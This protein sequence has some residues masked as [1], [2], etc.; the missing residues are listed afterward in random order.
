MERTIYMDDGL[1][2]F[3]KERSDQYKLYPSDK[4]WKNIHRSVQPKRRWN[5]VVLT[6]LMLTISSRLVETSDYHQFPNF[7]YLVNLPS[8]V[9]ASQPS[10]ERVFAE[11]ATV[12]PGLPVSYSFTKHEP[13]PLSVEVKNIPISDTRKILDIQ[14]DMKEEILLPEETAIAANETNLP[15]IRELGLIVRNV[16]NTTKLVTV[17]EQ[18]EEE[19]KEIRKVLWGGDPFKNNRLRWHISFS[20]TISYRKLTSGLENISEIF[21]GAPLPA[22]KS[23]ANVNNSVIQKPAVGA[24]V[25]A[26]FS[27]KL[28]E[29]FSV[30]AGL[31]LNYSRYQLRAMY[32]KPEQTTLAVGPYKDSLNVYTTLRNADGR[33]ASWLNNEYFQV[34]LPVGIEWTI[35]GNGSFK[36]NMAA[37]AQPVYNFANNIYLLST[38]FR[39]YAQDPSLVRKWNINAGVETFVSYKMGAFNWQAGP[40]L[41][42][43]LASSY[44]KQYP[45]NEYM[46]DFGFKVGVTK[47]I[48]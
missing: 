16:K 35:L 24:E 18:E 25:G 34:A 45:I 22:E 7:S 11:A 37:S 26:G 2:D 14:P 13:L 12:P 30:K 36:W 32:G 44:K 47:T 4:V 10:P 27:Y 46:V 3:L 17:E 33:A 15:D 38:D 6:L 39:H 43:Q 41:R 20:P 5:Y 31:Q 9:P 21:Q 28:S 8:G 29:R 1:E 23:V 19:P 42:Y 40:Q 48:F